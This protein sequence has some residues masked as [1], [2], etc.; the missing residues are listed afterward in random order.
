MT[1]KSLL[2]LGIVALVNAV[3]VATT[4]DILFG[5]QLGGICAALWV[6]AWFMATD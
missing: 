2:P 3:V 5:L 6:F 4:V 1:H